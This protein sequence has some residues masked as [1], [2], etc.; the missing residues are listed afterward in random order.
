VDEPLT[1][2]VVANTGADTKHFSQG[3]KVWVLP[4]QWGDGGEQLVVVGRRKGPANQQSRLVLDRRYLTNFRVK[5]LYQ[6]GIYDLLTKE[7]EVGRPRLWTSKEHA[8]SW[9]RFMQEHPTP[10]RYRNWTL[11]GVPI[12]TTD[13]PEPVLH[14]EDGTECRFVE[15]V[16]RVAWYD[17]GPPRNQ[18]GPSHERIR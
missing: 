12:W 4:P 13:P 17:K 7:V 9:A 2:C 5:P 3:A 1:W 10:V 14:A 8:E 15:M 6:Q 16:G 11:Y 18:D